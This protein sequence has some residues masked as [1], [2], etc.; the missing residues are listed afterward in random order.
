MTDTVIIRRSGNVVSVRSAVGLPP[1]SSGGGSGAIKIPFSYG[2]ATP[3]F[4]H[5]VSP[6]ETIFT[7]QIIIQVPFNGVDSALQLG[8]AEMS[9]RLIRAD[10]NDPSEVAEWETNPG[11]TYTLASQI[12]L[13]ITPGEGCTQGSGFILLE[14]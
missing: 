12:V 6:G 14:V 7:A 4:I 13:S 11:Y 10:Q 9:D 5:A 1:S 8:D 3:K 2:D